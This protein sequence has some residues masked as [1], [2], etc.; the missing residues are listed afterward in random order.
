MIPLKLQQFVLDFRNWPFIY[1]HIIGGTPASAGE[2]PFMAY[3]DLDGVYCG[4]TLIAEYVVVT[5]AH[6]LGSS[7]DSA[8]SYLVFL[9]TLSS[10][11]GG[12]GSMVRGV[13]FFVRHEDYGGIVSV[14]KKP[15]TEKPTTKKPTT[16]KP[17]TKPTTTKPKTTK[18]ST[19]KTTTKPKTTKKPVMRAFPGYANAAAVVNLPLKSKDDS[20]GPLL[21][22]GV[23]AG[24]TSYGRGCADPNYA[25]V[26]TRVSNYVGWIAKHQ[27]KHLGSMS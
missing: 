10:D 23:L 15:T 3:L 24:I 4:G 8:P 17:T 9:N 18:K 2:F 27:A 26:Y 11:G 1:I 13:S 19:V 21:V 5:A 12:D 22:D 25:G 20:G 14:S 6:C 16:K 7:N